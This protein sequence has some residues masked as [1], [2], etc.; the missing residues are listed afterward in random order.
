M[1]NN[2]ATGDS[3]SLSVGRN[4]KTESSITVSGWFDLIHTCGKTGKKTDYSGP[5]SILNAGLLAFADG[6][7]GLAGTAA[8]ITTGIW[9]SGVPT[10]FVSGAAITTTTYHQAAGGSAT[11]AT[12]VGNGDFDASGSATAIGSGSSSFNVNVF[13]GDGPATIWNASSGGT[14]PVLTSHDTMQI[15]NENAAQ[16]T[17]ESIFIVGCAGSAGDTERLLAGR[18]RSSSNSSQLNS[19]AGIVM[20]NSDTLDITYTISLLATV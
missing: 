3:L 6:L 9:I 20:S 8:G 5:N 13:Y 18:S 15:T 4:S 17:I 2:S 1:S 14:T 12:P 11:N 16:R 19:G 7:L 10:S